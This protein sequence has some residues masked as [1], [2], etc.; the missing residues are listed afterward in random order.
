V[1]LPGLE[2]GTSTDQAHS[3][4]AFKLLEREAAWCAK[5]HRPPGI[6]WEHLDQDKIAEVPALAA[7]AAQR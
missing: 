2:P 3:R 4:D 5:P 7:L 6:L 1:G